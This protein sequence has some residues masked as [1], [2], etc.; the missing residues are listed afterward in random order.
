MRVL[1]D[2]NLPHDL[3]ASFKSTLE[4]AAEASLLLHVI[5][6]SDP[7]FE[8]QLA[9]TDEVLNEIGAAAVPR[10]RIFNKIDMVGE[11]AAQ[12][13]SL[14]ARYADCIVM[15]ARR[16]EDVAN[17][18]AAIVALFQKNLLEAEIF[19]PWQAQQLRGAIFENCQ[20][21]AERTDDSGTFLRVRGEPDTVTRLRQR[22]TEAA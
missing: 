4:E 2:E 16:P 21:L 14:R 12:E 7:G 22:A 5:D 20:V 6:A 9:V 3:V 18:R 19:L 17:L 8:R 13:A 10:I 11:P 1:L 15:S